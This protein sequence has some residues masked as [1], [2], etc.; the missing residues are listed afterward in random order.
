LLKHAGYRYKQLGKGWEHFT[1]L[2]SVSCGLSST[3]ALFDGHA[4]C[5]TK[6]MQR[7]LDSF[8]AWYRHTFSGRVLSWR[9]QHTSVTM[10]ARF[11]GGNKEITVSL[12]Q[13]TVLL[14]FNEVDTL[15][16]EEL[17]ARTGIGE[18][19]CNECLCAGQAC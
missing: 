2:P 19:I 1:L 11:P 13:A 10:T 6:Q 18:G 14:Q 12:F 16:F 5:E 9:H 15:N 8:E 7:E 3:R 4:D 17:L